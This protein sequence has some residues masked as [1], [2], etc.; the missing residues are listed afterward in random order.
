MG[1]IGQFLSAAVEGGASDIFIISGL[2]VSF[3]AEGEIH[4]VGE[5]KIM[6]DKANMLVR[7]L[8]ELAGRDISHFLE[9]GDDDYSL[10]VKGLS[11]FRVC[12]YRQR[13]SMAAVIRTIA[14]GLPDRHALGLPDEVIK[15]AR[16]TQG[17]VLVTG[18]AGSGKSTTLATITNEIN[19]TRSAHI[20]TIEDPIEYLHRNDKSV[21]SQREVRTDT[22]SYVTA[23]RASLRQAP[24]VILLGEMRDLETIKTAMTAAETGHLVLATLHTIG[25]AN[26]VDRIIDVF[27][28]EQQQQ[29]RVQLSM[30]LQS[31]ITQQLIPTVNGG[32][33]PAFEIM[34]VNNAIRNMIRDSKVHQIDTV[35]Q[36]SAAEGM[37]SLDNSL[38]SLCREGKI[39]PQMA[40]R[41]AVNQ[42]Q[43]ERRL[44]QW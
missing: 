11:R 17:M 29:I 19:H 28:P 34:H 32:L 37:V 30:V 13:G 9:T 35:I 5:E 27:P 10:S 3:K 4:P 25:A 16:K 20:I 6:P 24:D 43:M 8:Y 2:P 41:Y 33:T 36:T 23:L 12:A 44:R 39:A 42:E 38:L 15:V 22:E 31:V 1:E 21:I 18:P 7:E 40:V 14:F 26:S